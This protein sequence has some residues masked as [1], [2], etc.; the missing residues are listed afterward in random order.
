MSILETV[1]SVYIRQ[2]KRHPLLTFI[3]FFAYFGVVVTFSFIAVN[4][5][6]LLSGPDV[7]S[8]FSSAVIDSIDP[9]KDI[10]QLS[11]RVK[12]IFRSHD[13]KANGELS[14]YGL[15]SLLED[16]FTKL[17]GEKNNSQ[18][19]DIL[20]GLIGKEKEKDPYY[21]LKFEQE[22]IIKN[23]ENQLQPSQG[24]LSFIEQIKEVIR[25]QNTEIDELKKSNAWGIPVGIAGV[26]L[27]LLFGVAS[28]LY[29]LLSKKQGLANG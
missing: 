14:E 7:K 6:S 23:L 19:L 17:S 22:V 21:G 26:V 24:G 8:D 18:K 11:N 29:P 27:T 16:S 4:E 10:E 3:G 1:V 25:R 20:I 15:V 12:V 28:L 9:E 2:F 5:K 13:R